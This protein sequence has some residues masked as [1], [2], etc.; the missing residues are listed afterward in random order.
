MSKVTFKVATTIRYVA[1][2]EVVIWRSEFDKK[3]VTI[4][5]SEPI[6]E[7]NSDG[8]SVWACY[9]KLDGLISIE[10]PVREFSSFRALVV[11]LQICRQLLRDES[12]GAT[13][14]MA[15]GDNNSELFPDGGM[16]IRELFETA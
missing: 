3:R 16:S 9:P 14:F 10:K 5:V 7:R 6:L 12:K 2:Q 4:R 15:V 8:S 1:E 13:L 11:A